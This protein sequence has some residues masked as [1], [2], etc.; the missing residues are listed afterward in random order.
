MKETMN[1][2]ISDTGFEYLVPKIID[3]WHRGKLALIKYEEHNFNYILIDE[4]SYMDKSGKY[5]F[6]ISRCMDKDRDNT[7]YRINVIENNGKKVNETIWCENP[8][9][10]NDI[11][12]KLNSVIKR[13]VQMVQLDDIIRIGADA[14]ECNK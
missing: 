2:F 3:L 8:N 10:C 13:T 4:T 6:V 7:I 1:G 11:E 5:T 12:K 14:D 9:V